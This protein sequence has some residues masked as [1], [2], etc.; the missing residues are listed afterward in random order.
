MTIAFLLVGAGL[1]LAYANGAND[2]FKGVATL[3]G[4]ATCDYRRA[5]AVATVATLLGSLTALVAAKGLLAAFSGKGLV[6]T[7]ALADPAFLPAVAV[8]AAATI[9]LATRLGMP[10]STTHALVGALIGGGVAAVGS[11]HLAPLVHTFLVPLLASPLIA[12]GAAALIYPLLSGGRRLLGVDKESCLCVGETGEPALAPVGGGA[13]TTSLDAAQIRITAATVDECASRYTGRVVGV[14]AQ[15]LLDGAH[16]ASAAAV[17]FARGLNDTPKIAALLLGVGAL[18]SDHAI[19]AVAVA[20]AAGGLIAARRV[21]E[22]LGHGVT[23][24]ND[25]QGFTANAVTAFLVIVASR[26]GV[27]VSTTH[28]STGALIGIG[29][30]TG[31]ARWRMITTIGLAWVATLPVAA[32]LAATTFTLLS[33]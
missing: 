13:C 8:G 28:V 1:L 5:L 32:V 31:G 11:V 15:S 26:W 30:A 10:V 27:P 20:I 7:A 18:G 33:R 25:G 24:M 14:E 2:N 9:L 22:T 12:L 21:A 19:I 3:F 23:T 29:A 4:S 16:Y 6:S 17:S